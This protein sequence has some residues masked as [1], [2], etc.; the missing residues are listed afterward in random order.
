MRQYSIDQVSIAWLGLDFSEGLAAGTSISEARN[1]PS[2]TVKATGRGRSVRVYNPDRTG[3]ISIVV[4]QESQ[5]H[6]DLKAIAQAD[7]RAATR[8]QVGTMVVKD[9]SSGESVQFSSAFIMTEPDFGR[10]TES[11]TFTWVFAYE[12]R[13]SAPAT[14]TNLVG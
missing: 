11:L 4:D 7:A 13:E 1:A 6:Q 3:T 12:K 14:L 10:A 9:A 5:L 2:W 8:S